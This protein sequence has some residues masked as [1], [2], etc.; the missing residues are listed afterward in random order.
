MKKHG[1]PRCSLTSVCGPGGVPLAERTKLGENALPAQTV[2]KH[3]PWRNVRRLIGGISE[4]APPSALRWQRPSKRID[5]HVP[6]GHISVSSIE[7]FVDFLLPLQ[8]GESLESIGKNAW[9]Q[10]GIVRIG[11]PCE[12]ER[13]WEI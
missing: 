9:A 11:L 6:D 13:E 7:R 1:V 10:G 4:E 12:D 5:L 8:Q 2:A 3:A